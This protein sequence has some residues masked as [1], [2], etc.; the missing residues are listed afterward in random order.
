M[1]RKG[2]DLTVYF[3][4]GTDNVHDININVGTPDKYGRV[5]TNTQDFIG[6]R[7]TV[8]VHQ[9][10]VQLSKDMLLESLKDTPYFKDI[11]YGTYENQQHEVSIEDGVKEKLSYFRAKVQNALAYGYGDYSGGLDAIM[12]QASALHE[13]VLRHSMTVE[14]E[15]QEAM[16][17]IAYLEQV[18]P[19]DF[20]SIPETPQQVEISLQDIYREIPPLRGKSP[21]ELQQ[22]LRE[23]S[24]RIT[25]GYIN[26]PVAISI[27]VKHPN[28]TEGKIIRTMFHGVPEIALQHISKQVNRIAQRLPIEVDI[29]NQ[30]LHGVDKQAILHIA[31]ELTYYYY[32][33]T[34]TLYR[35]Q[36]LKLF[37]KYWPAMEASGAYLRTK[38]SSDHKVAKDAFKRVIDKTL[39]NAK[40]RAKT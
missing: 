5:A 30:S 16:N 9:C 7:G 27:L 40:A 31:S 18:F 19:V 36:R 1:A 35:E 8:R 14:R 6:K 12:A 13:G 32:L 4:P 24:L 37:E 39:K 38:R 2:I 10:E 26:T 25:V 33:D 29:G 11:G 22:L 20:L 21:D 15:H 17:D 23:G 34:Q 3:E 28:K